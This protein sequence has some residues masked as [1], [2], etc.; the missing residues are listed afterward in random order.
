MKDGFGS[1]THNDR[2]P[3]Q[4]P[5]VLFPPKLSYWLPRCGHEKEKCE[6]GGVFVLFSSH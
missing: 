5:L 1:F 6:S 2:K 3:I 4:P